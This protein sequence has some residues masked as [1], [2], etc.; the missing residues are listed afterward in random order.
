VAR[1]GCMTSADSGAEGSAYSVLEAA[2][3]MVSD[4]CNLP[5]TRLQYGASA[6]DASSAWVAAQSRSSRM[7]A[8]R[9]A[10]GVV[11][12]SSG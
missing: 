5:H 12:A 8:V 3:G 4:Y 7:A 1:R 9:A 2:E 11:D 10:T 6:D